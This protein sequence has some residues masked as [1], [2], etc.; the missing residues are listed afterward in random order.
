MSDKAHNQ[1][2][3]RKGVLLFLG[4][5][6]FSGADSQSP[7]FTANQNTYFLPGLAHV[8]YGYL[9]SDWLAQQTDIVPAFSMLVSLV[10]S[11]GSHWIFYLLYFALSTVYALSITSIALF[12]IKRT[13]SNAPLVKQRFPSLQRNHKVYASWRGFC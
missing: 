13:E 12:A 10:H 8:G 5:L 3:G 1:T 7:L 9:K 11:V 6:L 2:L 4:C